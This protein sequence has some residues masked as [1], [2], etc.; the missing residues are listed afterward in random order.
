MHVKPPKR[1][2]NKGLAKAGAG[3]LRPPGRREQGGPGRLAY[4]HTA[5]ELLRP[6]EAFAAW[7]LGHEF[8]VGELPARHD[9]LRACA[10]RA[11][12][13]LGVLEPAE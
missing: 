11:L 2:K 1:G 10:A 7:P 9:F 4:I 3:D 6:M 5:A 13:G 8:R 12:L